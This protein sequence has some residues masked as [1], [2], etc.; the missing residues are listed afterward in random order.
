VVSTDEP[1]G[2][3]AGARLPTWTFE[4]SGCP[5]GLSLSNLCEAEAAPSGYGSL[6]SEIG[7]SFTDLA[8]ALTSDATV[9]EV[10]A[11]AVIE[12]PIVLIHELSGSSVGTAV[13][14]KKPKKRECI[15]KK[16]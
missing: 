15:K 2:C 13:V 16:K 7:E 14:Q 3:C 10:A 1:R 5:A 4:A 11:S 9:I 8:E 6:L 12:H